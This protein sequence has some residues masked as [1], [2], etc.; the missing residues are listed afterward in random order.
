[1]K[2]DQQHMTYTSKQRWYKS[3]NIRSRKRIHIQCVRNK[4]RLTPSSNLTTPKKILRNDTPR[5]STNVDRK[6]KRY[7]MSK[8]SDPITMTKSKRYTI[9][10]K[11]ARFRNS[12]MKTGMN[13]LTKRDTRAMVSRMTRLVIIRTIKH[14][15]MMRN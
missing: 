14:N 15:S 5:R 10:R 11:R 4:T 8:K 7:N 2:C 1:M 12:N 13:T 6:G 3:R 9:R